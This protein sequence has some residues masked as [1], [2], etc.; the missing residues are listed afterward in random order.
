MKYSIIPDIN[1]IQTAIDISAKYNAGWEINDFYE[2][3]VYDNPS[4]INR[5]VDTYNGIARDKSYDTMH[6]A[7]LGLDIAAMDTTL[8]N[9][10]RQLIV[11]SMHIADRLGVSGVVFHTGLIGTLREEH[12]RNNWLDQAVLFY[13]DLC[14]QYPSLIIYMENSFEQEPDVFV[15]LMNRMKNVSNFK[16]CLDYAHASITPVS[17]DKWVRML[18]PFI[19]HIHLNDNDLRDDLHQ[20]VGA[21][22]IDIREFLD[23]VERYNI[24][25]TC[26]I[27]V[28]D[29]NKQITSLEYLQGDSILPKRDSGDDILQQILDI[30]IAL[31]SEEDQG[32]LLNFIMDKAMKL[33]NSD[34]GTLYLLK[35]DGLH[36]R[37]MK[38]K[39]KGVDIG[40]DSEDI[41]LV[42]VPLRMENICAYAAINK[43][44]LI[45]DD[46]YDSKLFDFSGP[47]KYDQINNYKTTSMVAIPMINYENEVIGV[48]QL[49]NAMDDY[50]NIRPFSS[51]E[52]RILLALA[53]QTAICLANMVYLEDLSKQMWSFTEAMT[54]AIDARTPYN[55]SHTRKVAEYSA[56]IVDKINELHEQGLEDIYFSKEHKEQI[57]MAAYLHDI[58]KMIVPLEVMNKETRLGRYRRD[59][60]MRLGN[61][62]LH[63]EID[64]LNGA[65]PNDIYEL[66]KNKLTAAQALVDEVDKIGFINDEKM[67][68]VRECLEYRFVDSD[69]SESHPFFTDEEKECMQ[70][71]KGTLTDREREVMENHVV[72]TERILSKV[73]FNKS[74]A[75]API[76]A[77]QHHECINGSGYPRKLK[78]EQLG[79]ETRILA[80]ADICD[81]LLATDRP[82]KTPL[83]KEKAFGIM[84]SMADEGKLELKYV[85]YL[86]G[87]LN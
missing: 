51:D 85:E 70:I 84:K 57:V 87:C 64:H 2:P 68:E 1:D 33:T 80:V 21:G 14:R 65:C 31:S 30:G 47:I 37:I 25:A 34:A 75:M 53:S 50:G 61:W 48:M 40:K 42:P 81:A 5:L 54:E 38:T 26:L 12:Y 22:K 17:N 35:D 27:E 29:Y 82:Y 60:D 45:I 4:E 18:A 86:M 19:G 15:E 49:I 8:R 3:A 39:S 66:N 28:K 56:L 52:V 44:P 11:Q 10:S 76:W 63:N 67:A 32:T 83:P 69:R 59:I 36:F 62:L 43:E 20:A 74:F 58:G 23:L 6:G 24:E 16:L 41:N 73:Y 72:M 78:E 77:A 71:R 79:P 7:F 13:T 46:V 9:R 55:G